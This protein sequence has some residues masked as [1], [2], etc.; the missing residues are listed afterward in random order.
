MPKTPQPSH[1]S[2]R[3]FIAS[4]FAAGSAFA[5]GANMQGT[6]PPNIIF[7]LADDTH[8]PTPATG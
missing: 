4:A 8:A 2:R 3:S 7:I 1:L 6:R 5:L